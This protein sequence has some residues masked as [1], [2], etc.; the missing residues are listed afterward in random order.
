MAEPATSAL[1]ADQ[2]QRALEATGDLLAGVRDDQWGEPTPCTDWNVR[3]LVN[4]FVGGNHMFASILH[5]GQ[6]P[7]PEQTAQLRGTDH[8]HG[9]PVAAY[10]QAGWALQEAFRP[11]SRIVTMRGALLGTRAIDGASL[12]RLASLPS[13]DVLLARLAGGMAA[14]LAGMA[15]VLSANLR[16]LVGVLN[17]VA[18]KKRQTEGGSAA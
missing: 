2:L 16:N 11:Y 3:D 4:H 14:P 5:G 8:L 7:S 10:R 15:G 13:R 1:P 18:D 17:A 6:L 9:D 12:A